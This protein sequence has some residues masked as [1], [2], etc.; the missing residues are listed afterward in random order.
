[1]D[2]P[3]PAP[4][5]GPHP[6]LTCPELDPGLAWDLKRRSLYLLYAHLLEPVALAPGDPVACGQGLGAVGASGNALNPH[7]HLEVRTGPAGARFE[8]LAHYTAS[9][10]EDEMAGY[11]LW[12]VSGWFQPVDPAGLLLGGG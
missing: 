1:L 8:S 12:R 7:L 9:A 3:T 10:T 11:C 6:A 5:L 2:L 4:T